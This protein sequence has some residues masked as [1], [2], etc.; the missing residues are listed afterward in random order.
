M[1][2]DE[3]FGVYYRIVLHELD[4]NYYAVIHVIG[5][6]GI[7]KRFSRL[8]FTYPWSTLK[9]RILA[10]FPWCIHNMWCSSLIWNQV[11]IRTYYIFEKVSYQWEMILKRIIVVHQLWSS[12]NIYHHAYCSFNKMLEDKEFQVLAR[13]QLIF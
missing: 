7:A 10:F 2:Y 12:L 4:S 11:F 3:I 1:K 6:L 5:R 8:T 9:Y 13:I